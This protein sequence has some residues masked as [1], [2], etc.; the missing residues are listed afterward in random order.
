[1]LDLAGTTGSR[2]RPSAGGVAVSW[3]HAELDGEP[4]ASPVTGWPHR[5]L[6]DVDQ[7]S[8][9]QI[10]AC[11]DLAV[12]MRALRLR[13]ESLDLLRGEVV[14][15]AF[16]EPSTRTR[17]SF[18][19]ASAKD[20]PGAD[21]DLVAFFDSLHDMG[22]PVGI[23][24]HVRRSLG[25]NGTWLLVEPFAHDNVEN[26]LNPVGRLYYSA[27]TLVCT[28]ASLSQEVG[29]GLGAQA[30]EG[31]LRDVATKGGFQRFRRATETPF[32]LVFEARP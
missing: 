13:R 1:M 20:Y 6:L 5:H 19:V 3:P 11:L 32:N 17:V 14:G 27:S 29:L 26:N 16:C 18:E 25:S 10:E 2:H 31:R 24:S 23:G 21:Y 30:G 15:L 7:L 8:K 22:D 9:P 12:E 4:L 28:P